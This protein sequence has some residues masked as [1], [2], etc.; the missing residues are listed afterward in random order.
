MNT[1]TVIG[2]AEVAPQAQ[3]LEH[4]QYAGLAQFTLLSEAGELALRHYDRAPVIDGE[5]RRLGA[6]VPLADRS[7]HRTV[8]IDMQPYSSGEWLFT[9]HRVGQRVVAEQL[10]S[11]TDALIR[12]TNPE[13]SPIVK[14]IRVAQMEG[15]VLHPRQLQLLAR[16]GR[17]VLYEDDDVLAVNKPPYV[18]THWDSTHHVGV[19]EI[20]QHWRGYE[21]GPVHRLDHLTTGVLLFGK[22]KHSL[23]K[24]N[25]QF[26][27][28]SRA[29]LQKRYI[30]IVEGDF[31][32]EQ[33]IE[34][35]LRPEQRRMVVT[36]KD[37]GGKLAQTRVRKI[38]DIHSSAGDRSVVVVQLLTGRKHQIRAS[39]AHV[40]NPIVDDPTYNGRPTKGR[41]RLHA[42]Y[43]KIRQPRTGKPI[44]ISAPLPDDFTSAMSN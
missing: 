22:G 2:Q 28:K 35:Y 1:L 25:G 14:G 33:D 16:F 5:A 23:A 6:F 10:A 41:M 4:D 27:N 36:D 21:T 18:S 42:A 31:G 34:C 7:M 19:A 17:Y 11:A 3:L 38:A 9:A 26:A 39:L 32:E 13:M 37:G 8:H 12:S 24:L 30:A 40:G 43:L 44:E 29:D 15:A 20:V